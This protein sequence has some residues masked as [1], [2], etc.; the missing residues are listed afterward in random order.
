M[1]SKILEYLQDTESDYLSGQAMSQ[2]LGV[3]RAAIW[4]VIHQLREEGYEIEAVPRKG[5]HLIH[6]P[7]RLS[8]DCLAPYL[9][10]E[11]SIQPLIHFATISSTN[12]YAKSIALESSEGTIIIADEQTKGRGRRGRNWHSPAN[13]NIYLSMIL[14]PDL[15]IHQVPMFTQ[16]AAAA[17][18]EA[19]S[20]AL[21]QL[22]IKWPNDLLYE[23]RKIC[24]ILT[25]MSGEMH[26]LHYLVIGIGINVNTTQEDFPEDLQT[27]ASSMRIETGRELSRQQLAVQVIERLTFHY[28][29]VIKT[30]SFETILDICRA[31]SSLLGETINIHTRDSV[32]PAR[33]IQIDSEGRLIVDTKSGLQHLSSGEVSIRK[34]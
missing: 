6:Q 27:I 14:K 13:K 15:P 21:P 32:Q 20:T 17:V 3:S 28:N 10:P 24:G 5:Y 9:L 30:G 22:S 19:L 2:M 4:K 26:A 8:P 33:A 34:A 23:G 11:N 18:W 7:D 25:E 12:D 31:H 29:Q 16:L 1:K